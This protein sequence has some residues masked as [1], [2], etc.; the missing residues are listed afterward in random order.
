[1]NTATSASFQRRFAFIALI[2]VSVLLVLQYVGVTT[3][4]IDTDAIYNVSFAFFIAL[5]AKKSFE[6]HAFRDTFNLRR[7]KIDFRRENS[8]IELVI[9]IECIFAGFLPDISLEI[10]DQPGDAATDTL[11]TVG[12]IVALI[13]FFYRIF[14]L[15]MF[16]ARTE[17]YDNIYKITQKRI[18]RG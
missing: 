4:K 9:C 15:N 10:Y 2:V 12:L 13:L 6:S 17:S 14:F 16:N 18:G 5:M 1:M 7:I 8:V 11:T 3:G